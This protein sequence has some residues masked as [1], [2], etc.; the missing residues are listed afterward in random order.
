MRKQNTSNQIPGSLRQRNADPSTR[1][2]A[3]GNKIALL[4]G[5]F[6]LLLCLASLVSILLPRGEGTAYT[7]DI[8]QDGSLLMSIPLDRT[9]EDQIFPIIG[10]N[11]CINEVEIRQGSIRIRSADCPD[12]LCVRQGFIS[13][14]RIPI[15]C[16]PNRL[17][18]RLRSV[19]EDTDREEEVTD[20][21]TY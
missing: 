9:T 6:L 13:D 8:F 12:K 1:L 2:I 15:T 14:S 16:L 7:A 19:S 4:L 3:H 21:V 10:K 11:G 18:I 20:M 17:V 5:G